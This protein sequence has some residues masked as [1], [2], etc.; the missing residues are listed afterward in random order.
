MKLALF[1]I[2]LVGCATSVYPYY[3][4]DCER[5]VL[6][7]TIDERISE[8]PW[9]DCV[10]EIARQGRPAI[11]VLS[12]AIGITT[13]CVVWDGGPRATIIL[14]AILTDLHREHELA[15][16]AGMR[17]PALFTYPQWQA[18]QEAS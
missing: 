4:V 7:V 16:L 3:V 9:A 11:E 18:C 1:A 14:P 15:H 10:A 5:G 13:A 6:P 12:A 8:T 17:H 2:L